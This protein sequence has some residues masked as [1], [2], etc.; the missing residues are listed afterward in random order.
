MNRISHLSLEGVIT[1]HVH[2]IIRYNVEE[3]VVH[4]ASLTAVI[5]IWYCRMISSHICMHG[6]CASRAKVYQSSQ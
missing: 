3:G 2:T 4:I 1:N 6:L 5:S